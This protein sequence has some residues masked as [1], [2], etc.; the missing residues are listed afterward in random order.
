MEDSLRY[1]N[2]PRNFY[3]IGVFVLIFQN[4]VVPSK[5]WKPQVQ[6]VEHCCRPREVHG[7]LQGL[8]GKKQ[9]KQYTTTTVM[10]NFLILVY[11][12]KLYILTVL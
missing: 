4:N 12:L 1:V 2:R 7:L 3:R 9:L 6:W 8:D 10:I 11:S 5:R